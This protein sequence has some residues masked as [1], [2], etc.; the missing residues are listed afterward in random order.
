MRF[1]DLRHGMA[2][3]LLTSG[4]TLK[5]IQAILGHGDYKSTL[6]YAHIAPEVLR[7]NADRI[8]AALG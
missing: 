1:H 3:M 2:T 6:I 5:E 4:A 8:Q 7:R